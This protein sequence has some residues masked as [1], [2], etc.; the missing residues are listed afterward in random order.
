MKA[1]RLHTEAM[2]EVDVFWAWAIG[3]SLAYA[4]TMPLANALADRI[5]GYFDLRRY[6][7]PYVNH[8]F[9][10]NLLYL[11]L[12]FAPSGACLLWEHTHWE[13]MFFL[14]ECV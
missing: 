9:L 1:L 10:C 7:E 4:S 8:Y 2:I 3:G 5:Q 13:T 12:L 14:D 6:K 11:S